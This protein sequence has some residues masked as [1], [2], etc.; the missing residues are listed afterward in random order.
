MRIKYLWALALLAA[1]PLAAQAQQGLP[2]IE[3]PLRVG[4]PSGQGDGAGRSRE[5]AWMPVYVKISGGPRGVKAGE[6]HLVVEAPDAEETPYRTTV[7]FPTLAANEDFFA[8]AY[9]RQTSSEFQVWL[10]FADGQQVPKSR[11]TERASNEPLRGSE[12]LFV[13]IGGF[14]SAALKKVLTPP[15]NQPGEVPP[16]PGGPGMKGGPQPVPP[17]MMKDAPRPPGNDKQPV[18]DKEEAPDN[19]DEVVVTD[20]VA[21]SYAYIGAIQDMPENW[22]GYDAADVVVLMTDDADFLKK[23]ANA[24]ARR[25]ALVEWVRRGGKLVISLGSKAADVA[26]LLENMPL[27]EADKGRLLDCDIE[28]NVQRKVL[29]KLNA[30]AQLPPETRLRDVTVAKLVPGRGTRV[31]LN[32]PAD[33]APVKPETLAAGIG[34]IGARV[35]PLRYDPEP[36]P[37]IVDSACGLGRVVLVAFDLDARPFTGWPGQVGFWKRLREETAPGLKVANEPGSRTYFNSG[38]GNETGREL[39]RE[40]RNDVE[41]FGEVPTIHFGWV[42]LFIVVYIV[43]VGPLDYLVLSKVFKRLELTWVTFPAVV[44]TLSIG[45]YFGAYALKGDKRRFN[46]MDLVEIDLASQQAYGTSWFAIFSPRIENYTIGVEPIFPGKALTPQNTRDGHSPVVTVLEAPQGINTLRTGSRS[47]FNRPYEYAPD[48]TGLERVPIPVWSIRSFTASWRTPLPEQPPILVTGENDQDL[49]TLYVDRNGRV[50]GTIKNNLPITLKDVFLFY[51]GKWYRPPD[52]TGRQGYTLAGKGPDGTP[53]GSFPVQSWNLGPAFDVSLPGRPYADWFD[54][55]VMF[56]D[57][58]RGVV[59]KNRN[60]G[61]FQGVTGIGLPPH[62]V[63]KRS[64]FLIDRD[65]QGVQGFDNAGLR[66]LDQEWRFHEVQETG[67]PNT[68]KHYLDEVILV[69]RTDFMDDKDAQSVN[70]KSLVRL[71]IGDLPKAGA[72]APPLTGQTTENTFVRVYIPVR[73]RR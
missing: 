43:I 62:D 37:L 19:P 23:L 57:L 60:P 66:R 50:K 16:F 30:W 28:F 15:K 69:A 35:A 3:P 59:V 29:S 51:Q 55:G 10:E 46:K 11:S 48:A 44:L 7:P 36:R 54:Q 52:Q 45:A 67:A 9:L 32:E 21:N 68:P 70:E 6:Y 41:T 17:P 27:P 65:R 38:Y 72:K 14:P 34:A 13:V 31:L 22:Y 71:W 56:P 33:D 25:K 24:P 12:P 42:A 8:I 18:K 5:G 73:P 53:G 61:G 64:M 47:L 63:L 49:H 20:S 39:L 58:D 40:L 4:L 2:K 1:L 26:D